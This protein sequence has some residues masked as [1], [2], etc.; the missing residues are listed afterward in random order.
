M[1]NRDE[2]DQKSNSVERFYLDMDE[3]KRVE[4]QYHLEMHYMRYHFAR[5]NVKGLVLDVS[6]GCGYGTYM[7]TQKTPD[8][9]QVIGLDISQE[10][11]DYANAH[12]KNDKNKFIC[13]SVK[14][15]TYDKPINYAVS[16]ETI[17]H[18]ENPAE[19]ADLF[20]RVNVDE[21][22]I[23]YPSRK[24][25]HYNPYHFHDLNIDDIKS[26]FSPHYV[27]FDQ[28]QYHREFTYVFLKKNQ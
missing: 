6:C 18:L 1:K 23:T 14:D 20:R 22:L 16:I 11:I 7:L 19:L 24:T 5:Q 17:E 3:L 8:V 13:S 21:A 26:I 4:R 27:V 10:A 9:D 2:V 12:Y 15:F 28:Y 25:T